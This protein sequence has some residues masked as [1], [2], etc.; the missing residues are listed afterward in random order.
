MN[1]GIIIQARLTSSRFAQK[2]AARITPAQNLLEFIAQPVSRMKLP[3][4]IAFPDTA[5]HR[6]FARTLRL[7]NID[8]FFGDEDNVLER[9]IQASARF[10]FTSAVRVCGDNPCLSM[11]FLNELISGWTEELDYRAYFDARGTPGT[12]T[13]YGLFSEIASVSALRRI[14]ESTDENYYTEHVTPYFYEHPDLFR[15]SR[16]SMPEPFWSGIPLRFTVDTQA[17]FDMMKDIAA[18]V[19]VRDVKALVD[20]CRKE[21]IQAAMRK[22]IAQNSK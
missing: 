14:K 16:I 10:G 4:V 18:H 19:N 8:Y 12:K 20:Y 2:I 5:E 21:S 13:H 11:P 3:T 7:E 6:A 9:F 15:I 17:D 1:L 22:E